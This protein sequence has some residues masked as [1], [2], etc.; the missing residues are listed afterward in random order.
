[1]TASWGERF[2]LYFDRASERLVGFETLDTDPMLGDTTGR[3]ILGDYR[4]A[5]SLMLPHRV[6]VLQ[7]DQPYSDVRYASIAVNG[8]T[9]L[10]VFEIPADLA[11]QA[12]QAREAD[13]PWVPLTWTPVDDGVFHVVA[14]SHHSM[15]VEFPTFVAVVEAPYTE[16]QSLALARLIGER[17]PDK[18]IRF[19]AVSHPHWDHIGGV[20]GMAS[21]G[22]TIVVASG[23]ESRVRT[24]ARPSH[25]NP[26]DRLQ[27]ARA[28]GSP[29]AIEIFDESWAITEEG[30]TLSL[31]EVSGSPH[32]E[33]VVLAYVSPGQVLFQSDLFFPGTGAPGTPASRHLEDSIREL[34]LTV[35]TLVGGHGGVGPF[36]EL[37]S[38]NRAN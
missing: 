32:V 28:A 5:G 25:T 14:Y 6:T 7:D 1:M 10:D 36:S 27:E 18:P 12:E 37:T 4:E 20:R 19:A 29:G 3:Y 8:E 30:Q 21:L 15:V 22:A 2:N 33:P 38:A 9:D 13:G 31:Y 35:R 11:A 23:H 34:R 24:V 26:P 16:A 17:I